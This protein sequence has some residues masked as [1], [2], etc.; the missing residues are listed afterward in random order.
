MNLFA[1]A[2]IS[3]SCSIS[4]ARPRTFADGCITTLNSARFLRQKLSVLLYQVGSIYPVYYTNNTTVGVRYKPA[5]IPTRGV[6]I[7]GR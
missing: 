1:H 2:L 6:T 7:P 3:L 4:A 5:C